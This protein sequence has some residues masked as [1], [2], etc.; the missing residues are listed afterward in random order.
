MTPE[1]WQQIDKLMD[2]ALEL[3][4]N[5]RSAFLEEACGGDEELRRE[6][7]KLLLAHQQ[8]GGFL[9]SPAVEVAVRGI[10]QD[11]KPSLLGRQI[12]AYKIVSLLGAGGMGEVYRAQ[13]TRLKRSVAIKVLP[14]HLSDDAD[15]RQRFEREARVVSSLNHPHIC[16]LYDIG[17]QD[18]VDFL[19]MEYLE[20]ET[21]ARRLEKGPLPLDQVLRYAIEIAGA[22]D[23][24]HRYGIVH[25]DLKPGNVMLTK[26]GAKLLDF[27]L[28]KRQSARDASGDSGLST[29]KESLTEKGMMLGTLAYMA[30][31]QVEGKEADAR[32]DIF[33]LGVVIYEMATGKKAFEGE[34]KASLAVAILTSQPSPITTLQ[35]L[36]PAALERVVRKSLAKD[37]EERWQSVR[38]LGDELKWIADSL[39]HPEVSAPIEVRSRR[40]AWL[41]WASALL[42]LF[43][44]LAEWF[45]HKSYFERPTVETKAVRFTFPP[46]D[47]K[48]GAFPFISPDGQNLAIMSGG[49]L[50]IRPLN[51]DKTYSLAKIGD[52]TLD[53]IWSPDGRFIAYWEKETHKATLKKIEVT[54]EFPPRFVRHPF[55]QPLPMSPDSNLAW[56][57][58]TGKGPSYSCE[59]RNPKGSPECRP[60]VEHRY[61]SLLLMNHD[62]KRITSVLAFSPTAGTSSMAS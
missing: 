17:R 30:P 33:A 14:A 43:I 32:T 22:L 15:L 31:E 5:Q 29:E 6:V 34:S 7:E 57:H 60:R 46:P 50:W 55:Q 38:D 49:T 53:P 18:G 24:A 26:T 10:G 28:A 58:G 11:Q 4:V 40:S 44:S 25:R 51:S 61:R 9:G 8:A 23:E 27:G 56:E 35:P 59:V 36:T 19:V 1:R 45:V 21:L 42:I 62:R 16:T 12:G 48:S 3:E 39:S 20:G 2:A 41:V 52:N 47:I 37:P 54:S 13:D